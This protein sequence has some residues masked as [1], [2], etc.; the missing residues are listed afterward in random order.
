M[1]GVERVELVVRG[2]GVRSL[3]RAFQEV[4]EDDRELYDGDGFVVAVTEN[5]PRWEFSGVQTTV[6]MEVTDEATCAVT[7]VAG[8]DTYGL[9]GAQGVG[10]TKEARRIEQ[11]LETFCEDR[12]LTIERV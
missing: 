11:L 12:D 10:E 1:V 5:H 3:P 9:A 2:D 8:G 4:P 6:I 7:I